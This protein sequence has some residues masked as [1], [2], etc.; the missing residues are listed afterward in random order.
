MTCSTWSTPRRP[1]WATGKRGRPPSDVSS[2]ASFC[3]GAKAK[4]TAQWENRPHELPTP[5]PSSK[6]MAFAPL[7]LS[8][9]FILMTFMQ[10]VACFWPYLC[11]ATITLINSILTPWSRSPEN[12]FIIQTSQLG[13]APWRLSLWHFPSLTAP[14]ILL[15][16]WTSCACLCKKV[17]K[18]AFKRA[19]TLFIALNDFVSFN[20]MQILIIMQNIFCICGL[21][22][23][24]GFEDISFLPS[25][26]AL[27]FWKLSG[28]LMDPGLSDK[29]IPSIWFALVYMRRTHSICICRD[30]QWILWGLGVKI[31]WISFK[32]IMWKTSVLMW[33]EYRSFHFVREKN[34]QFHHIWLWE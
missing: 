19:L 11:V 13:S 33:I 12:H 30:V 9:I 3:P 22:T 23:K 32:T 31:F 17:Y 34:Q 26:W 10:V 14:T 25:T 24:A 6:L 18:T 7:H 5:S 2:T 4:P 16:L 27:T 20:L 29:G 15:H 8:N 28:D 1:W 21:L